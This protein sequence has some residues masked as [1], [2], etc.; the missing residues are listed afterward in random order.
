MKKLLTILGA[1][2]ITTVGTVNIVS[3]TVRPNDNSSDTNG[4]MQNDMAILT[5][6][7]SKVS[8]NIND[9]ANNGNLKDSN[10][11]PQL[12]SFYDLVSESQP[13]IEISASSGDHKE[14]LSIIKNGLKVVFENVNQQIKDEYSNYYINTMPLSF[15]ETRDKFVLNYINLTKVAEITGTD[16]SNLKTVQLQYS[17]MLNLDYK[18]LNQK[19]PFTISFLI[20]ND[21]EKIGKLVNGTI[22][23]VT[24]VLV[25]YFKDYMNIVIDKNNDFKSIYNNF[26]VNYVGDVKALDD[27]FV[28]KLGQNI[29]D[30]STISLKLKQGIAFDDT[31]NKRLMKV[32]SSTITAENSGQ[33]PKNLDLGNYQPA[34]WAGEGVNPTGLTANNFVKAYRESLPVFNVDKE[35][36]MLAKLNVNL[37]YISIYGLPLS[38]ILMINDQ[39]YESNILISRQGLNNKLTNFGEIIV[40]FH[41]YYNIDI[42]KRKGENTWNNTINNS[43][44]F[45]VKDVLSDLKNNI[46]SKDKILRKL[47]SNFKKSEVAQ[48][49]TD[50]NLFN[51][52][53]L[54]DDTKTRVGTNGYTKDKIIFDVSNGSFCL[55]FSFGITRMDSIFYGAY[56]ANNGQASNHFWNAWFLIDK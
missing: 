11:Y 1:L 23:E 19:M 31:G 34:L 24:K 8:K 12:D 7:A 27:I 10:A 39:I 5:K 21:I 54:I 44:I 45:H 22:A 43:S 30:D 4:S 42:R 20:S 47:L 48:G 26:Q 40:A 28:T 46:D 32:V 55:A 53:N 6:I 36:M 16:I 3:C 9:Y 52:Y 2:T 38:G 35:N 50:L 33:I 56:G 15:E 29:K 25:S 37:N 17:F 18:K 51:I 41:K 13:S 49:L 14:G